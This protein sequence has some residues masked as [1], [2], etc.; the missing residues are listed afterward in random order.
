MFS[1]FNKPFPLPRALQLV[2]LLLLGACTPQ[3]TLEKF[4]S[5]A[6]QAVAQQYIDDLRHRQFAAIEK[7]ADPTIAGPDMANALDRM[8]ELIPAGDP[9]S[10]KLVGAQ[11]VTSAGATTV[12]L[13]LEYQFAD[14]WLLTNVMTKAKDGATTLVGF[15]VEPE[16]D[17]LEATNRFS[18]AGKGALQYGVLAAACLAALI[19]LVALIT[20]I[21]TTMARRKWL[22]ILFILFGFGKLWVNWTTGKWGIQPLSFQLFSASNVSALYGPWIVSVSLPVGA[23]VFLTQRK[24]LAVEAYRTA[25]TSMNIDDFWEVIDNAYREAPSDSGAR[26]RVLARLLEQLPTEALSL[27]AEH[28]DASMD[29]AYTWPLWGAAYVIGGGCS[30]DAFA[31][32]RG[33]L[34]SRGRAAF[35]QA[36]SAPDSLAEINLDETE[37]FHEGFGYLP[38]QALKKRLGTVRIGSKPSPTE[39]SGAPWS[40]EDLPT[41]FPRLSARYG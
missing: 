27:F 12:N 26:E 28:F 38:T 19:S 22:W 11:R 10:I 40:D 33:S 18:W 35:E 6:E 24:R 25:K 31:D 5:P 7:D 13:N 8:A 21:R 17:S 1:R 34:I 30:D 9:T 15:H 37:W 29:T 32:F 14:R 3:A 2:P 16:A 4:T 36:I 23:V 39:P 20:C 41:L